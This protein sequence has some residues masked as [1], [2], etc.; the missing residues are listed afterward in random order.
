MNSAIVL[1][2]ALRVGCLSS[3]YLNKRQVTGE[4]WYSL[5]EN[6]VIL[7][8]ASFLLFERPLQVSFSKK[9]LTEERI[10]TLK[11]IQR[12]TTYPGQRQVCR[13]SSSMRW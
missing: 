7:G 3:L 8:T 11:G 9:D 5:V 6:E 1:K 2:E 13:L 4:I 10:P 12:H